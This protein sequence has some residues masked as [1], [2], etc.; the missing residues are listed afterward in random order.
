MTVPARRPEAVVDLVAVDPVDDG[1]SDATVFDL[2]QTGDA[3]G[4]PGALVTILSVTGGAPRPAGTHMAVLSDGR[5]VGY[6]SGGCV[7]PAI[8]RAVLEMIARGESGMLR[9]GAGSPWLDLRLPCGGGLALQVMVAPDARTIARIRDAIRAR[10]TVS[11]EFAPTFALDD[12]LAA[13]GWRD[14]VFHRRYVPDVRLVVAGDGREASTLA[15]IAGVS[16]MDVRRAPMRDDIAPYVDRR[17]AIVLLD[18]DH[19]RELP[20][21]LRAL[22]TDAFYIGA[23]GSVRT[24]DVRC[25]ALRTL[26]VTEAALS[27]IH[28]PIGL[29]DRTRDSRA[30]AFSILAEIVREA[31]RDEAAP[32]T[33]INPQPFATPAI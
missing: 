13:T 29:V 31:A 11:A 12:R 15:R 1:V 2:L 28:A 27:R 32:A 4:I 10:R 22:A 19:E 5:Y 7:E 17:T 30:L 23:M 9:I 18:H 8:A 24:H 25:E 33:M 20:M 3:E 6:V 14:G 21:L 26:G 16:G